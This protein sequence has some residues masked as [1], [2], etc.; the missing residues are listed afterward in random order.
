MQ[1][2]AQDA[3]HVRIVVDDLKAQPVEIDA[4]HARSLKT[5]SPA[6]SAGESSCTVENRR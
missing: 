6:L 2:R 1:Q 5:Q 4:D 3:P